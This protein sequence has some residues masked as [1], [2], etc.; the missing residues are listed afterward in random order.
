LWRW[1]IVIQADNN[2][3]HARRFLILSVLEDCEE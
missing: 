1:P 3:V 2:A